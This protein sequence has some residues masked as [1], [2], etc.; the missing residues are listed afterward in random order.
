MISINWDTLR[1]ILIWTLLQWIP[2]DILADIQAIEKE[3][4]QF[5]SLTNLENGNFTLN[6]MTIPKFGYK[7]I[8]KTN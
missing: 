7:E 8:N 6:I 1:R 5:L 2:I 3:S 4:F